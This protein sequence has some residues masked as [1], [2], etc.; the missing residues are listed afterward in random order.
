[1]NRRNVI[2]ASTLWLYCI[3]FS[4]LTVAETVAGYRL[5][6][7][8]AVEAV[9]GQIPPVTGDGPVRLLADADF[10]PYSFASQT[11][12]P[13][14][15]TVELALAACAEIKLRCEVSL[16]PFGELLAA[17]ERGEGDVI[18]SGPRIDEATLDSALMTR[19]WFRTMARFAAP[20]GTPLKQ[21]DAVSL[22]G[23]RIGVTKDTVHARWLATYYRQSEVVAFESEAKAGEALRTGA[24]DVLFGDNL[25]LI[26]WVAGPVSR[27]CCRLLGGA[28]S[29]FDAFSRNISFLVNAGRPDL[30][31]AFDYGLDMAQTSGATEK[32]IN[33]YVP[34]SPW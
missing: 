18:V 11:G 22:Q 6:G 20:A 12:G 13:S 1:M 23:K 33:A 8:R 32:I 3:A 4:A 29:D 15:L 21:S 17:L 5:P 25:R 31:A 30:R 2:L 27:D 26:Y 28:Y 19:P 10:P 34:L 14:G 24:V 9:S 16:R 7:F